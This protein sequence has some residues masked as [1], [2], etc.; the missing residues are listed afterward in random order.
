MAVLNL[1][2]LC[3][4]GTIRGH[5]P[6]TVVCWG[7]VAISA[8]EVYAHEIHNYGI[9]AHKSRYAHK[10]HAHE[11]PAHEMLA[12]EIPVHEMLAYEMPAYKMHA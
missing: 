2:W 1:S 12:H 7:G 4:F 8:W 6:N 5:P 9:P 10:I 3:N 11:M